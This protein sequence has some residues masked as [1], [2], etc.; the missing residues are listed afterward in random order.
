MTYEEYKALPKLVKIID[1]EC[2]EGEVKEMLWGVFGIKI[3]F[4]YDKTLGVWDK[5]KSDF[6]IFKENQ[7]QRMTPVK[8]NGEY[9]GEGDTITYDNKKYTVIEY[10]YDEKG[11]VISTLN[12]DKEQIWFYANE[13]HSHTPLYTTNT[14]K[15]IELTN[16][17]LVEELEKRGLLENGKI[18]KA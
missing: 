5:D 4:Y 6:W 8:F 16:E 2:Y 1:V 3:D 10:G 17:Q 14:N 9:I 7:V 12:Q 15:K 18:L 11:I 13:I